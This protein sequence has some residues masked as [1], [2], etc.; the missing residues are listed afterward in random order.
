M[1]TSRLKS[2]ESRT[3]TTTND[4]NLSAD[5][6][7]NAGFT[8]RG[9]DPW[10]VTL[11]NRFNRT[12][13]PFVQTDTTGTFA[14]QETNDNLNRDVTLSTGMAPLRR[15]RLTGSVSYRN[16]DVNRVVDT[17]R[18]QQSID[19]ALR[20]TAAYQFTDSTRVDLRGEW[21]RA[22]SLYDSAQ[23]EF[24]NGDTVNRVMGGTVRR[25]LGSRAGF[26]VAGS[27]TV[28]SYIFDDPVENTDDRD[29]VHGDVAAR[30]DY[31]PIK[32]IATNLR[33]TV[34]HNRT[35]FIDGSKSASNQTQQVY[36][37]LPAFEYKITPRL[38]FREEGS[39]IA[40]VTYFDYN[41]DN[42]RLSRTTELR[43]TIDAR[44]MPRLGINLRHGL[45]ILQDGSYTRGEDGIRRFGKS[46]EDQSRDL[47]FRADYTAIQ[48]I[49]L[50][51][52][53]NT[54]LSDI[55]TLQVRGD[56]IVETLT[57]TEFTEI[58][59]GLQVNRT[60]EMGPTVGANLRRYQ[61]WNDRNTRNNYWVGNL[62]CSYAF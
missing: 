43:S 59:V 22:R 53:T 36:S 17:Q 10:K 1:R 46:R 23:R 37:I 11:G 32:K 7:L 5:I 24:L 35:I 14:L 30:L 2:T 4:Q 44:L 27:Y 20:G 41:E 56:R 54:R 8:V 28:Q 40:N 26:D 42:N 15:L 6:S 39:A 61:S 19:R 55:T 9:F 48:G 57:S 50:N 49:Q 18:S 29:I 62:S 25:P 33:F 12:Q 3:N 16:S 52:R 58:E 31:N 45:R 51:F 47:T 60:L 13:Y 34:Q 38:T 21:S